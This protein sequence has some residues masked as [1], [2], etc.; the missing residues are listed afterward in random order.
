MHRGATNAVSEPTGL[1]GVVAQALLPVLL[2]L[3]RQEWLCYHPDFCSSSGIQKKLSV[4][5]GQFR[6]VD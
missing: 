5:S 1:T 4:V 2:F 6:A 3:H